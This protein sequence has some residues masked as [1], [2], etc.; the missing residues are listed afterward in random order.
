MHQAVGRSFPRTEP[1]LNLLTCSGCARICPDGTLQA[2]IRSK[3]TS[4]LLAKISELEKLGSEKDRLI[5]STVNG[6][7]SPTELQHQFASLARPAPGDDIPPIL[8]S[9]AGH[10]PATDFMPAAFSCAEL[11]QR[12]HQAQQQQHDRQAPIEDDPSISSLLDGIG[13]LNV[14]SDGRSRYLGMCV[15]LLLTVGTRSGTSQECG[16]R[17]H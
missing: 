2:K 13:T 15:C 12:Q 4:V 8:A 14:G 11:Q 1:M 3:D 5:T 7:L 17:L 9:V 6:D 10:G 16:K